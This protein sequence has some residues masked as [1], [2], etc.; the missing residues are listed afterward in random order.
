MINAMV[1][2]EKE[3][4]SSEPCPVSISESDVIRRKDR[5]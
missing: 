4:P 5:S 2:R 1:R 3:G